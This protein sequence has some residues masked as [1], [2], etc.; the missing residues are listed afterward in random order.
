MPFE[1][2][3]SPI[4]GPCDESAK[5][6]VYIWGKLTSQPSLKVFA[7]TIMAALSNDEKIYIETSRTVRPR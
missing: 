5:V 1:A 4:P 3:C 7:V 2:Y 6:E